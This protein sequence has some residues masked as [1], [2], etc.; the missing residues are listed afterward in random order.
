[1]NYKV[2]ALGLLL[3]INVNLVKSQKL[4]L[5]YN[6]EFIKDTLKKSV[7]NRKMVLLIEKQNY[8]FCTEDLLI[9]DSLKNNH[10]EYS[11]VI[12]DEEINF[13]IK[14]KDNVLSKYYLV[15]E[16]LYTT[17]ENM[18]N[19]NWQIKNQ[20]KTIDDIKC[21]L[22]TLIYKGRNWEAWFSTKYS[23]SYG[24]YIFHG[25]PGV[26]I[27]LRDTKSNYI[28][29][30]LQI[31]DTKEDINRLIN[32][33]VW[34]DEKGLK[35]NK[36]QLKKLY[37]TEYADPFRRMKEKKII[38]MIDE[39]TGEKQPPPDFDKMTKSAQKYIRDTNNPIE[40]SEAIKYSK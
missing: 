12:M 35:I 18:L 34:V 40:L 39:K 27:E 6:L 14:K 25:L 19:L 22:A 21:Q 23:I 13:M 2:I 36:E 20:I 29:K 32:Q 11:P 7:E 30:L 1:M 5:Y 26:I 28:F 15:N 33:P 24:P 4:K 31:K 17:N 37:L 16:N 10:L 38:Y 9:K 8:I 3:I